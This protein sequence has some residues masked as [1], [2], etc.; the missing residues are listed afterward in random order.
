M[1][2]FEPRLITMTVGDD[3]PVIGRVW[4]ISEKDLIVFLMRAQQGETPDDLMFELVL[5][6]EQRDA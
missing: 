4:A 5:S 1:A 6:T 3:G 2:R